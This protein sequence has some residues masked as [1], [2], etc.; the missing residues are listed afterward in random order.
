MPLGDTVSS[1]FLLR[2]IKIT[3][4]N[5][6]MKPKMFHRVSRSLRMKKA[7][8]GVKSGIVAMM[9][10]LTTGAEFNSP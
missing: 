7:A 9:A 10:E 1:R 3:P 8:I 5:E 4:K 6:M 2:S